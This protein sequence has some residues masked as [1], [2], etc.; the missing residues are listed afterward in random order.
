FP[1]IKGPQH[2]LR[3]RYDRHGCQIESQQRGR[4][5]SA[6]H[7]HELIEGVLVNRFVVETLAPQERG[8]CLRPTLPSLV[9]RCSPDR[10]LAGIVALRARHRRCQR[11]TPRQVSELF[12][13]W[14]SQERLLVRLVTRLQTIEQLL[15]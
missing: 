7:R 14:R 10:D 9:L 1:P 6:S 4:F 15:Y 2:H 11:L 13:T 3:P 5:R 8:T 12:E